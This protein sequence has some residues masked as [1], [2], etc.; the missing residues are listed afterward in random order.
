M[1]P[2]FIGLMLVL[3]GLLALLSCGGGGGGGG[4]VITPDKTLSV[5]FKDSSGNPLSNVNIMANGSLV[6]TTNTFGEL[7][8]NKG[9]YNGKVKLQVLSSG[10]PLFESE[11]SVDETAT[12]MEVRAK[13][14]SSGS[15][16]GFLP[17]EGQ[18]KV[19]L[20]GYVRD[21]SDNTIT[22]SGAH[23]LLAGDNGFIFAAFS[24]S[25]GKYR[26]YDIPNGDYKLIGLKLGYDVSVS[27]AT[28]TDTEVTQDVFLANNGTIP[29]NGYVL[30]G[31]VTDKA[32]KPL[33]NASVELFL[34]PEPYIYY[35]GIDNGSGGDAA[36]REDYTSPSDGQDSANPAPLPKDPRF[37]PNGGMNNQS[38]NSNERNA[39]DSNSEGSSPSF[40]G[41]CMPPVD[42]YRFTNTNEKGEYYFDKIFSV[43]AD[44]YVN[45]EDYRPSRESINFVGKTEFVVNFELEPVVYTSLSGKVI[46][47]ETSE[48]LVG[49]SVSLACIDDRFYPMPMYDATG[50]SS[51]EETE[52]KYSPDG[53]YAPGGEVRPGVLGFYNAVT[54]KNGEY[55]FDKV[56]VG[57]Y[58]SS[59]Y[60]DKYEC[61][62]IELELKE[63]ANTYDYKL[64]KVYYCSVN[65]VVKDA[66]GKPIKGAFVSWGSGIWYSSDDIVYGANGT[67]ESANARNTSDNSTPTEPYP[68]Y[69]EGMGKYYDITDSEGKYSITEVPVG[70][71]NAFIMA[72]ADRY[73]T[74]GVDI[75]TAKN[76]TI[77]VPD[78][79]LQTIWDTE[80]VVSGAVTDKTGE[81]VPD[82]Y[83]WAVYDIS[84]GTYAPMVIIDDD[85]TDKNG[86]YRLRV[87]KGTVTIC[88]AHP[89]YETYTQSYFAN[90]NPE[91]PNIL[92]IVLTEDNNQNNPPKQ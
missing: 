78:I 18:E 2:R 36:T 7:K 87:P 21:S 3:F 69:D 50:K 45:C 13:Q 84:D 57:D 10:V 52:P 28:I 34:Q 15:G 80:V 62:G 17:P 47:S 48:P 14:S 71:G 68:D 88:A 67:R 39:S 25:D 61:Y 46:D 4:D 19:K 82:A 29:S 12:N 1:K 60:I 35:G 38:W 31:V 79:V 41:D 91:T 32:G 37:G 75:K 30:K 58:F 20:S 65:G 49:A 16:S 44:I 59:V 92:N 33:A 24:E 23:L 73:L 56:P 26:F 86:N 27:D 6:G 85:Y 81:A 66:S 64:I 40:P 89:G 63:S 72:N 53:C 5:V 42:Y 55:K 76:Q 83:V 11:E 43:G 54:D 8:L 51:S 74:N 9:K 77:T 70:D 22:I 90:N